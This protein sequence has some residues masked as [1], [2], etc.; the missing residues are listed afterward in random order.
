VLQPLALW[1]GDLKRSKRGVLDR[2]IAGLF[3]AI[4]DDREAISAAEEGGEFGELVP[5][6]D[7]IKDRL[8]APAWQVLGERIN[9]MLDQE[10]AVPTPVIY[11]WS[12]DLAHPWRAEYRDGKIYIEGPLLD[13]PIGCAKYWSETAER[14]LHEE[15]GVIRH[16]HY[17]ENG[18]PL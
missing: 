6:Q 13:F 4:A 2:R 1:L 12:R 10:N 8:G 5:F 14:I 7:F 11:E 18:D 15:Q 9:A 17:G 16:R 3:A